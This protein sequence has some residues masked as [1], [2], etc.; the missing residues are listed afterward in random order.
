MQLAFGHNGIANVL[1]GTGK[2]TEVLDAFRKALG[3]YQQLP[4]DGI[5]LQSG[6]GSIYGR[7]LQ[8]G[9]YLSLGRWLHSAGQVAEAL[10]SYRKASEILEA[11]PTPTRPTP[12]FWS[13]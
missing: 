6:Y 13:I 2:L 5:Y 10:E 9:V 1:A 11:W 8:A 12:R 3:I 7:Q 4:E